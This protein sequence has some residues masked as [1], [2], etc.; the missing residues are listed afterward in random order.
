MKLSLVIVTVLFSELL[1]PQVPRRFDIIIHEIFAD[2]TPQ[3][4]L[5]NSEFIELRNI[6]A[7]A[8]NLRNWKI[9]DGSSTATININYVLQADSCVVVCPTAAV[10]AFS[11]FGPAIGVTGFPSLNNDADVVWLI[12]PDGRAMHAV[13]YET[14]WYRN[15][16]K[17]DGG[18]S[19]EMIDAGNPC[20]GADNW[21]GSMNARGGTPAKKNSVEGHS[22]DER[23]PALM[24]T[25]T[26]DSVT[27]V[28]VFDESLDS[29]S[30]AVNTHYRFSNGMVAARASPVPPLFRQVTIGLPG[31]LVTDSVYILTVAD[32]ADCAGNSIGILNT[33]RVG[34][35]SK[36]APG[37]IV[38]NE[39]LFNPRPAG[40]DYVELYNRS[41][42]VIDAASLFIGK[43]KLSK[44]SF[45]IFPGDY[46]VVTE[47]AELVQSQ[48]TVKHPM[49]LLVVDQLPSMPDDKGSVVLQNTEGLIIDE[50]S[51]DEKWHF[52]LL[53][54]REG[55]ALE[56][57]S[58]R[59]STQQKDNWA[60]A[61]SDA[62]Y[63]T[64][65]SRNSQY[66]NG[67]L[68][69]GSVE[70]SPRVFSPDNDGRDDWCL[71]RYNLSTANSVATVTVFDL[72]G[73]IVRNL[74][75]TVTLSGQGFL[76][77]DGLDNKG[78]KL[79]TGIY[80]ILTELFNVQGKKKIF[81]NTVTIAHSF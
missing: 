3:V 63:G 62:G 54:N 49:N 41:D 37:D 78:N 38:I 8:V 18:W 72:N 67:P 45:L 74:Y 36:A 20:G 56:R 26:V 42:R 50:L 64:P 73:N 59:D 17:S 11:P 81:K 71:I 15:A 66:N 9:S 57:I 1:M 53:I 79:A 35:T 34:L 14:S 47:N 43:S 51:Y 5:P 39:V 16:V 24:R 55:V 29:A 52:P 2:P 70:I 7:A 60:S 31:R 22:P 28:A 6:S 40:T 65:T 10:A 30:A 25:Y 21:T 19:L 12:A 76:R 48:Y 68:L 46:I 80:I 13:A 77:W 69:Q 32:V 27:V 33:A 23:P 75:S 58:A 61:A 44:T 4:G